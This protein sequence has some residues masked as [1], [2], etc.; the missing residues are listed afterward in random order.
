MTP[1][2]SI[3]MGSTSDPVSYTHLLAIDSFGPFPQRC[4]M[5]VFGLCTMVIEC[6]MLD[7]VMSVQR[8]SVQFMIFSHKYQEIASAITK[9]TRCV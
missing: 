8:Q 3:I 5:V 4:Q 7:Y 9:K 6:T 2:V 1:L